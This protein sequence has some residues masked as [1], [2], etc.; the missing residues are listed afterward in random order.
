MKILIDTHILIWI[1][2]NNPRL[3]DAQKTLLKDIKNEICISQMSFIEL[4]IKLKI[5]KLPEFILSIADVINETHMSGIQI[6][7][8]STEHIENYKN[9]PL[10][11]NHRDPFDR[12]ILSVA[13]YEK[14]SVMSSDEKFNEYAGLIDLV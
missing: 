8:L 6:I 1:L 5:G 7:P 11:E 10:V 13:L 14:F 3:S 12:F 2:E 9:I 4:A